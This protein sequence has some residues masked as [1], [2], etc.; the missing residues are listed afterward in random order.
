M[1][2]TVI[3]GAEVRARWRVSWCT[4]AL[5][6]EYAYV[7]IIGHLDAVDRADVD[8]P[9]R[10]VGGAGRARAAAAGLGEEERDFT[11]R[12]STLSHAASRYSASGAPQV[13]PALFTRMCE[14]GL[15]LGDCVG[16]RDGTP[17]SVERS[18]GRR[19][20]S[21]SLDSSAATSSHTSALRDEM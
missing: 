7:S 15:A 18:A 8:D 12:S 3:V 20:H 21:P 1:A 10:V 17:A 14:R 16:E 13:A 4:A 5:L 2:F 11:L 9:G 6:D 19:W